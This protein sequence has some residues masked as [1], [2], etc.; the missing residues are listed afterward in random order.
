MK[1]NIKE[2]HTDFEMTEERGKTQNF[3]QWRNEGLGSSIKNYTEMKENTQ[4][5]YKELGRTE[6]SVEYDWKML[7]WQKGC[8]DICIHPE[9]K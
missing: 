1:E 2:V 3:Q 8:P 5:V 9:G 7:E 4:E 6:E